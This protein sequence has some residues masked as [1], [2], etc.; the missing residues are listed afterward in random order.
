[1]ELFLSVLKAFA[2]GGLLCVAA[3]ILIDRTQLSPARIL[4][5]FV[6]A[7]V[8][9]GALGLYGPLVQFAGRGATVPLSGFGYAIAKGVKEAVDRD[10]LYGI[11]TGALCAASG[12]TCAAL[13]LGFLASLIFRGKPK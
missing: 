11:L 6:V 13:L 2:I 4:V 1:M 3:Q 12:G 7:G 9:F 8:L 5:A 10:G